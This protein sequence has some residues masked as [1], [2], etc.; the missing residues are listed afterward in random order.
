MRRA[1]GALLRKLRSRQSE[2]SGK[3]TLYREILNLKFCP[4]PTRTQPW[5]RNKRDFIRECLWHIVNTLDWVR[6]IE[7]VSAESHEAAADF[8][9]HRNR[10]TD[11]D[12]ILYVLAENHPDVFLEIADDPLTN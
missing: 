1:V 4:L 9:W 12:R 5:V 10:V 7:A 11:A 6:Y 8:R 2:K 3:R